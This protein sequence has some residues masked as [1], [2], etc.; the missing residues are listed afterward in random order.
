LVCKE[1]ALIKEALDAYA[2][3]L[4]RRFDHTTRRLTVGASEI[5]SCARRTCYDKH[6]VPPDAGFVDHPATRGA[7]ME[8]A[9]WHPAMRLT[10][11]NNLKMAGP[12]Q[13]TLKAPP[14]S[15]TPD[16]LLINLERDA[17]K[18]LG[19]KDIGAGRCIL[20][21]GK[22]IDPRVNL[23]KA[24]AENEAQVQVQLGLIR[25]QTHYWPNY[26]V[27]SYTD[28]SFWSEVTEF[29]VKFD[30]GFFIKAEQRAAK[31]LACEPHEMKP[32]GWIA[33]GKEC[34]YCPW[35]QRCGGTRRDVPEQD[36]PADPQFKAEISDMVTDL[37]NRRVVSG[38][39]EEAVREMEQAIKDRLR[40]KKVRKIPGVVVW[41]AVKGRQSYDNEAIREAAK[42]KG[43][44]VERFSTVGEPTDRLLVQIVT[45]SNKRT[46]RNGKTVNKNRINY[47][48]G[49]PEEV[50]A[51]RG[52]GDRP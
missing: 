20:V 52:R 41:S 6:A 32:E 22:T 5:G 28:A 35:V 10:F 38:L 12:N 47:N 11:G 40:E 45:D 49:N 2:A 27:I 48:V 26:A 15:A 30:S 36:A 3:V 37:V 8:Q 1:E 42:R 44:N 50:A 23:V 18:H 7:V 16:G 24:K 43:V 25:K 21:E 9:F 19:I 29:V 39:Q 46:P 14:L 31:I 4:D 51:S 33:G 17:L 13:V 34:E